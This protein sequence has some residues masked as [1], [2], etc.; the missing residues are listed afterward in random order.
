[1]GFRLDGLAASLTGDPKD[2]QTHGPGGIGN[3]SNWAV[4]FAR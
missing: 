2:D 3:G 4:I 1:L